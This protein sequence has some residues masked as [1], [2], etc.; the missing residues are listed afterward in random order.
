MT[1]RPLLALDA[2]DPERVTLPHG[3]EVTLRRAVAMSE[4]T[5]AMGTVGRIT[6]HPAPGRVEVTVAG[7]GCLDL[8]RADVAPRTDGQLAHA[9]R[10]ARVEAALLPCALA[11]ATVGSRAWNLSHEGSDHDTRGVLLW[12]F[13]WA[14][15]LPPQKQGAV[16]DV[17][18]SA[19]GSHTLWEVG[20]TIEQALRADPNTL[21]MLFVPSVEHLDPLAATL[22]ETREVFVSQR[23]YGSFG[24]YAVAQA[25]KLRQSLRLARHRDAVLGW[26]RNDDALLLDAVAARLASEAVEPSGNPKDDTLRAK[27]YLKQ[28]YR[29]MFDQGLLAAC[30][31]EALATFARTEASAFDLPRELRP[32]NAYNLLR[33]VACAVQWLRTGTPII[34]TEGALR[35]RLL[36][37]K[38]GEVDLDTALRWTD[39]A[40]ADLDPARDASALPEHPNDEA[41]A[42]LLLRLREEA[43]RRWLHAADGP[44]SRDGAADPRSLL[45]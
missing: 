29:S 4:H 18:V 24:R 12:P 5:L 16:P 41:A 44:W 8:A 26:L 10:R 17:V 14:S 2:F 30:S 36:S 21:E 35:D 6:G 23:L 40:A 7:R 13:S 45:R 43:A 42:Q 15:A 9:V 32:K 11:R 27:Q 3:C 28:L 31:F 34:A 19:D 33:I 38:R 20:R 25:K 39:E 37:I 22:F 1:D